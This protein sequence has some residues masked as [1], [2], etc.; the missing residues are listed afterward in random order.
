MIAHWHLP[1]NLGNTF[2]QIRQNKEARDLDC[3]CVTW[4]ASDP[5]DVGGAKSTRQIRHFYVGQF[6]TRDDKNYERAK[7]RARQF[8]IE[9]RKEKVQLA[10]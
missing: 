4:P 2:K 8:A 7:E 1:K 6:Y 10:F 5:A 9:Y 3:W